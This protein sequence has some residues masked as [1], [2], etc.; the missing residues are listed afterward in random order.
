MS[1]SDDEI[2]TS[3]SKSQMVTVMA[4]AP[5]L[6]KNARAKRT[7]PGVSSGGTKRQRKGVDLVEEGAESKQVQPKEYDKS[8]AKG[9][10]PGGIDGDNK[11]KRK[12]VRAIMFLV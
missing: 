11:R 9:K 8:T 4:T 10:P 2:A 12:G 3:R 6:K 5:S 1:D 7:C